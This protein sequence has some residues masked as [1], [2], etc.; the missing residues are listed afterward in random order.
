MKKKAPEIFE[1]APIGFVRTPFA[2]RFGVPRQPGL[3]SEARG[4]IKLNPD[5]DLKTALKKLNEFTHLWII[6]VFHAHG[7]KNWKPSIRPPRLGGARKVGVLA[8]RSPHR[9]NPIG[10]SAV[11]LEKIDFA[12]EG[13]PEIHVSGVDLIDQT[14]V[15]DIK[16]YLPYADSI[17]QAGSGWASQ[18]IPRYA[19]TFTAEAQAQLQQYDPDNKQKLHDLIVSVLELDPRPAFQKRQKPVAEA[20][21][22]GARYGFDVAGFDIKYEIQP[23]GF[24][25]IALMPL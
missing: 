3:A 15:L 12:A 18:P 24:L 22:Q 17:P 2:D 21:S 7:G 5:P 20:S 19:V 14:P 8:S 13:G 4:V 11:A 16:P 23:Q 9:P 6:F 1:F 25:V 10:L